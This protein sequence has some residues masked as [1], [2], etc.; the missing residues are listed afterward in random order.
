[1]NWYSNDNILMSSNALDI[2]FLSCQGVAKRVF[3][4]WQFLPCFSHAINIR[5]C[6]IH[7]GFSTAMGVAKELP[8]GFSCF[9]NSSLA[10]PMPST[11]ENAAFIGFFTAGVS[12][13]G[14]AKRFFVFWQF[15]PCFSHA[16]DTRKRSI[17]RVFYCGGEL[18]RSFQ[19]DFRVLAIPMLKLH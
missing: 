9:G 19:M 7:R 10:F 18:P 1:M 8:N 12:C 5:K 13:Q 6:S 11:L 17:H 3:V 16:I 4:F 14:V 15:L 2:I